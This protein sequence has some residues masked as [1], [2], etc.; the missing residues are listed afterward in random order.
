VN[1]NR[2]VVT[3]NGVPEFSSTGS[4]TLQAVLYESGRIQLGWA[5][6]TARDA[7]VGLSPGGTPASVAVDF[8]TFTTTS[9]F[10]GPLALYEQFFSSRPFDMDNG[11]VIFEPNSQAG[12]DVVFIPAFMTSMLGSITGTITD[13]DGGPCANAVL[14]ITSSA[15]P[16]YLGVVSTDAEGAY[17]ID[18]VP[19][20]AGVNVKV[21]GRED[22]VGSKVVSGEE[23]QTSIN[24]LPIPPEEMTKEGD[25]DDE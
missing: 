12:Y 17:A 15:V 2:V 14:E 10:D 9:F 4:N 8:S 16:G 19:F 24:V 18:G 1:P 20:G 13:T 23:V 25:P 3:W 6:M 21:A 7:I 22:L 5:G 11:F